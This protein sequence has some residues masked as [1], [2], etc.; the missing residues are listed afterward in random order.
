MTKKHLH[1]LQK[2]YDSDVIRLNEAYANPSE[3]KESAY[4]NCISA[5][6]DHRGFADCIPSHNGWK[7]SYAFLF[8]K[9]NEETGVV[10]L[11]LYYRTKEYV[12][13]F[14]ICD[15]TYGQFWEDIREVLRNNQ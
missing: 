6:I 8:E 13:E 14:Y 15:F 5:K 1:M 3:D 9:V 10:E 12:D 7:F 4:K 2:W 11:W